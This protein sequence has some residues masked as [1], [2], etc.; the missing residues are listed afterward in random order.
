MSSIE[1][2][3]GNSSL[4]TS[5]CVIGSGPAGG[6]VATELASKGEEVTL[7]EA[8]GEKDAFDY[9]TLG[10]VNLDSDY[11]LSLGRSFQLGGS[12]NLWA[13]R[14]AKLD[15]IDFTFRNW[16][17][18]ISWPISSTSLKNYYKRA[19]KIIGIPEEIFEDN[20]F[21][22]KN[23][24]FKNLF[25]QKEVVPKPFVWSKPPFSIADYVKEQELLSNGRL[26]IVSDAVISE[27]KCDKYGQVN[28]AL[29]T[30]KKRNKSKIYAKYFILATGGLEVPRIMLNSN[31]T[32]L[33]GI[34]NSNGLVGRYLSTHPKAD[35]AILKLKKPIFT[36]NALFSDQLLNKSSLRLGIKFSDDIQI[37]R[38]LLNHYVQFS[39]F[40]ELQASRMFEIIKKKAFT[41]KFITPKQ[42]RGRFFSELGLWA[43][44]KIG[45][46]AKIQPLTKSLI[47]RGFLDQ[48][49]NFENRVKIS[50]NLD[51]FGIKKIDLD[52]KFTQ[53]DKESVLV[54][55]ELLRDTF[56]K[57]N[58]G[59][60]DFSGLKSLDDW[61]LNSLHSH[62]LG[63]TRMSNDPKLGVVDENCKV[64]DSKNLFIAGPSVFSS[65]GNANPFLTICALSL[66]LAEHLI[67]IKKNNIVE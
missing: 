10:N 9:D 26:K 17:N 34:G 36:N 20:F 44:N 53:K 21:L 28:F 41:S 33:E 16:V 67:K 19:L 66:R 18:E 58:I 43:F 51:V 65:Y 48:Y 22:N 24:K 4:T 30:G 14:L 46:V 52:W 31:E 64:F 37:N 32:F 1:K 12:S 57:N 3:E 2:I 55:L 7:L 5:Y 56:L 25:S 40:S 23:K 6:I 60:L 38:K 15:D 47:V 50:N 39:S 35:L 45:L 54:F 49:P 29:F 11:D 62:Y 63:T 13:G 61:P 27:L 8:G 42:A 59:D